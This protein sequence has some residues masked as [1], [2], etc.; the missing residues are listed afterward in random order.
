VRIAILGTFDLQN[1]GDLLFPLLARHELGKRFDELELLPSSYHAKEKPAWPYR[2]YSIQELPDRLGALDGV[3]VGGGHLVRFDPEVAA[4]YAP[5]PGI[6]HPTGLW[7]MPALLAAASGLPV[8]WNGIGTSPH[9][10][11]W[12]APLL[13]ATLESSALVSVGD[14]ASQATL[15]AIALSANLQR[16]CGA[17][18]PHPWEA[19]RRLLRR[20]GG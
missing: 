17:L 6:D 12:A 3:I 8:V 9:V 10:D 4:G 19:L 1:Y 5:P 20:R 16:A 11:E 18:F 14:S 2:V 15:R 7:L 13:R